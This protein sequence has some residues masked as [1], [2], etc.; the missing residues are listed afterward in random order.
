L[1]DDSLSGL[2]AIAIILLAHAIITILYSALVNAQLGQL[3]EMGD[4]G[5]KRAQQAAAVIA[6]PKF[7][8]TYQVI[9]T[10]LRFAIVAAAILGVAGS[11]LDQ[12]PSLNATVIYGV[13]IALIAFLTLL[14]GDFV[15]DAVGSRYTNSLVV[16][17]AVV[18]QTLV[19]IFSPAVYL[20]LIT[21][22]A[23]STI[24]KSGAMVRTVTEE[25]IMT[26][27]DAGL[28]GGAIE[29]E[30]KDMIYSVLQLGETRVSEVM[31]PRI[32]VVAV[33]INQTLKEAR[34]IFVQSGYSR[35]PVY[36][37]SVDS[38]K[39]VLHAKDLLAHWNNGDDDKKTISDLMRDAYFVPETKFADE[40]LKELQS[41]MV[42]VG[43]V[44][45]EYGGTAGLVTIEDIIEEIIGEIQDEYD[46]NEEASYELIGENEYLMEASLDLDDFNNLLDVDLPTEDSDTLGGYIYT[47]FGR[48]PVEG[49]TI[50]N[51]D[52]R[53]R[54]K[55]IDGRRI[56]KV[57]VIRKIT[58]ETMNESGKNNTA[59]ER[60]TAAA[61]G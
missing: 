34:E 29:D 49:D 7:S 60:P 37:G 44:I 30:E 53:L 32:D 33:E 8:I 55:S 39:G 2:L 17:S 56:R 3:R 40:L 48:V 14:L 47:H 43:I 52:F 50:E 23:I 18:M 35:I 45:D 15:P 38:V 61:P 13:T 9:A 51:D 21:S 27:I 5:Q 11:I 20:L 57:H 22:K 12:N 24:F 1:G 41:Q 36:E 19:R 46:F 16:V 28:T 58:D 31:V 25:E 42:H 54:I 4:E 6:D 26:M 10:L 59:N